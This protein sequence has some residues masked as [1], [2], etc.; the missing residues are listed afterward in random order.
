MSEEE[1]SRKRTREHEESK[2]KE[3]K[4]RCCTWNLKPILLWFFFLL[5]LGIG[6]NTPEEGRGRF[7]FAEVCSQSR[8]WREESRTSTYFGVQV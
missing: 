6:S 7:G 8:I 3:S 2:D 5:K 4:E 1:C